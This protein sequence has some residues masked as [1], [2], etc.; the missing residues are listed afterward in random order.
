MTTN[1]TRTLSDS[2]F[3]VPVDDRYFEDY[4][5]GAVYEYGYITVTE[6]EI[7]EFAERFDPQPMHIDREFAASGPFGGLIA[8]GW[9]TSAIGMRLLV[10]HYIS[11]VAGLASPGVDELRWPSPVRPGDSLRLRTTIIDARASRS[12]PDRGIVTTGGE[13]L[14][15]DDDR[16]VLTMRA[17]NLIR[18]RPQP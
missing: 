1:G 11:R 15:K 13:L 7:L 18:R 5:P 17:V 6:E 16:T 4:R 12:K 3:A 10:D 8:S 2:D 14:T 9:H